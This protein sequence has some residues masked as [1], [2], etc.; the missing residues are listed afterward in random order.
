M[1]TESIDDGHLFK[2][3]KRIWDGKAGYEEQDEVAPQP[4]EL[5]TDEIVAEETD[6][7]AVLEQELADEEAQ[8]EQTEE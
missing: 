8:M 2:I 6:E 4:E 1:N 5:E 7:L 3:Y